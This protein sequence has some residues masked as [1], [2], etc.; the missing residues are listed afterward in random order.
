MIPDEQTAAWM[1]HTLPVHIKTYRKWMPSDRK[2]QA[3]KEMREAY[4][5][6]PAESTAV[7]APSEMAAVMEELARLK[8]QNTKLAKANAALVDAM[9]EDD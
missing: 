9:A 4:V 8:K 2:R 5:G 3:M 1:G 6:K 7:D